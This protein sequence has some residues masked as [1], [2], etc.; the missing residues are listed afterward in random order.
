MSQRRFAET[1]GV[2]QQTVARLERSAVACSLAT[3]LTLLATTG[4]TLGVV[5]ADGVRFGK[6][7]RPSPCAPGRTPPGWAACAG[8]RF[9]GHLRA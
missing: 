3:I 6:K 9:S 7:P 4:H 5:D 2:S 1:V 8:R